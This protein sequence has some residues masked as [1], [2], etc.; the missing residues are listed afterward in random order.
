MTETTPRQQKQSSALTRA[1]LRHARSALTDRRGVAIPEFALTFTVFFMLLFGI[2]EVGHVLWTLNAL[3]MTT[4]QAVRYLTV[5]SSCDQATLDSWVSQ[6]S[7][8]G[9]SGLPGGATF[10][11]ATSSANNSDCIHKNN[12]P[13]TPVYYYCQVTATY[14]F[15]LYIPFVSM[16]P[17]LRA[18]SCFPVVN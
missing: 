5:K 16:E 14:P 6:A 18:Q 2:I 17:Q 3:H 10:T 1:A 13:T 9:G 7:N 11:P 12:P 8:N 4:Q 15:Q